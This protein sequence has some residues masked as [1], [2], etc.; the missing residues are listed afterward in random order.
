M[1]AKSASE[2]IRERSLS[3]QRERHQAES[4][5]GAAVQAAATLLAGTDAASPVAINTEQL[6]SLADLIQLYI[7]TGENP[8]K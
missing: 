8:P 5:R 4:N 2:Q 3:D 6:F 1:T 7:I